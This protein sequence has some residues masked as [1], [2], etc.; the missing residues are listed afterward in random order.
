MVPWSVMSPS[1]YFVKLG[2]LLVI[3]KTHS[4]IL[5]PN[6]SRPFDARRSELN[7][8]VGIFC[9]YF[10]YVFDATRWTSEN[11]NGIIACSA[12]RC[13]YRRIL[14][15]GQS[16]VLPPSSNLWD[17]QTQNGR[18]SDSKLLF[19]LL[20]GSEDIIAER[21]QSRRNH[22]MNPCLLRSQLAALEYP[23]P[24]E[25]VLV[26]DVSQTVNDIVETILKA[27]SSS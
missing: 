27:I 4:S 14:E 16:N 5:T 26:V 9:H 11:V 18:I 2:S 3:D 25:N 15:V 1:I 17:V 13:S 7:L 12:L 20:N 22:F 6:V 19:V 24:D 23:S 21:L 10:V 8:P